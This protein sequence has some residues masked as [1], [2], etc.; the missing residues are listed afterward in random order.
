VK[1]QLPHHE[2][3]GLPS[4]KFLIFLFRVIFDAEIHMVKLRTKIRSPGKCGERFKVEKMLSAYPF[5]VKE[6][7]R[8]RLLLFV[9]FSVAHS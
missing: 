6:L 8:F 5:L 3:C 4:H 7:V 1:L 2:L 9:V